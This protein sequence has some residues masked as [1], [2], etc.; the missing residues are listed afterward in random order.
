MTED[1]NKPTSKAGS[2]TSIDLNITVSFEWTPEDS[3]HK[4]YDFPWWIPHT[5]ESDMNELPI[6]ADDGDNGDGSDH[7]HTSAFVPT[8]WVCIRCGKIN[9]MRWV[10]RSNCECHPI[11]SY[12]YLS[13]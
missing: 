5:D 9:R 11:V 7:Y 1:M 12:I 3:M 6:G 10:T 4:W 2:K 13:C 8:S